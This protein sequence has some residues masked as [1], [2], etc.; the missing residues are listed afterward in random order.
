MMDPQSD[1]RKLIADFVRDNTEVPQL[2]V[3]RE[4][5]PLF[6]LFLLI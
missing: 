1:V 4:V 3:G 6:S 2:K 5:Y